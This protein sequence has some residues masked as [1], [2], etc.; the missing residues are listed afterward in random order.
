M[1][2]SP[3]ETIIYTCGVKP[4]NRYSSDDAT[5]ETSSDS[6][7]LNIT[8]GLSNDIDKVL[9]QVREQF[10]HN[11]GCSISDDCVA[12]TSSTVERSRCELATERVKTCL[13]ERNRA[14]TM[15]NVNSKLIPPPL[16]RAEELVKEAE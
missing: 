4:N 2:T 13:E 16:S 9:N 10:R 7:N 3:S 15:G 6:D 12:S 5:M 11:S 14:E 1:V 8:N